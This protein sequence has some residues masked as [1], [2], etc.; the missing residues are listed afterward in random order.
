MFSIRKALPFFLSQKIH[1]EITIPHI[2]VVNLS[3]DHA[4]SY[5]PGDSSFL[6]RDLR[7]NL[8]TGACLLV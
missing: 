4:Y 3:L 7:S 8:E 5:V 1:R 2:T 6:T